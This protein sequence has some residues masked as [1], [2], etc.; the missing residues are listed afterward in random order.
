MAQ[1]LLPAITASSSASAAVVVPAKITTPQAS[2]LFAPLPGP[3]AYAGAVGLPPPPL[4]RAYYGLPADKVVLCNFNQLYK[5]DPPV[6]A[7]WL[8]ILQRAP[9]TVL[10]LLR[11]PAAGESNLRQVIAAAGIAQD[12][13]VFS[14]VAGKSE[15]IRRGALADLCL[16]TRACNGHTTGMDMLWAG[17]PMITCP[18]LTLASRVAASQLTALGC[19][20]LVVP[21]LDAYVELAVRLASDPAALA[22]TQV[23]SF[24]FFFFSIEI[25]S[26]RW[27]TWL[28]Q[29]AACAC[30]VAA[31]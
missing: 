2:P 20:E 16:D 1:Q 23:F 31:L 9:N 22:A 15:H 21:D 5:I 6:F 18:N 11:F 19:P 17:T 13:V 4:T 24:L 29:S 7:A 12:R 25:V 3:F 26:L 8:R 27:S 14:N 28:G 30:N 10:W